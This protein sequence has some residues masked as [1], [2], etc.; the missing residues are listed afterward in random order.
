MAETI[1]PSKEVVK[2]HAQAMTRPVPKFIENQVVWE[3]DYCISDDEI[4]DGRLAVVKKVEWSDIGNGWRVTAEVP[5]WPKAAVEQWT[6]RSGIPG[7]IPTQ[8]EITMREDSFRALTPSE[9]R[10]P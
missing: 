2:K 8:G 1:I 6:E 7:A 5:D 9:Y 10:A 4:V 3:R